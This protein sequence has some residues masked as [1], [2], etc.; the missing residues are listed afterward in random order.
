MSYVQWA[1]QMD[2]R[3]NGWKQRSHVFLPMLV[4]A[5]KVLIAHSRGLF[6]VTLMRCMLL[7]LVM[8]AWHL[9]AFAECMLQAGMSPPRRNDNK[10]PDLHLMDEFGRWRPRMQRISYFNDI[11]KKILSTEMFTIG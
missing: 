10:T 1:F 4:M 7:A 9:P 11:G 2:A 6:V 3:C 8:D 5:L